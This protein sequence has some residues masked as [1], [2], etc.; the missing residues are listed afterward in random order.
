MHLYP[1]TRVS[2]FY[3]RQHADA[4]ATKRLMVYFGGNTK[5]G[6]QIHSSV[7]GKFPIR[8]YIIVPTYHSTCC[9]FQ[10]SLRKKMSF[11]LFFAQ[12][13]YCFP[14]NINSQSIQ[15][16]YLSIYLSIYICL[17][18]YLSTFLSIYIGR[19]SNIY[20]LATRFLRLDREIFMS[21]IG[22]NNEEDINKH[23][24]NLF[25]CVFI[26]LCMCDRILKSEKYECQ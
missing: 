24:T 3:S 13:Q 1:F 18:I 4:S 7:F 20:L 12:R 16:I 21:F 5:K 19:V 6:E 17:S 2:S 23:I 10:I 14:A 11:F 22:T 25:V 8:Q 15:Y 9:Y 26:C